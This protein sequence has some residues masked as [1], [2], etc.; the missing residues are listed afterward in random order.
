MDPACAGKGTGCHNKTDVDLLHQ[1][2][3]ISNLCFKK[4]YGLKWEISWCQGDAENRKMKV[5]LWPSYTN[6]HAV[7]HTYALEHTLT[8]PTHRKCPTF[9]ALVRLETVAQGGCSIT[10][11]NVS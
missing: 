1:G 5:V 4:T 6:E 8:H 9:V 2:R 10:L 7:T 3:G 11:L